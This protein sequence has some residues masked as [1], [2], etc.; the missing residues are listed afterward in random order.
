MPANI[1]DQNASGLKHLLMTNSSGMKKTNNMS[2]MVLLTVLSIREIKCV[3]SVE[4]IG[5]G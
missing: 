4:K 1:A 5:P 3:L 2:Q